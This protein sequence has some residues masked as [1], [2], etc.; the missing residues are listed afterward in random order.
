MRAQLPGLIL[1]YDATGSGR[2]LLLLHGYPLSRRIWQPQFET[3]LDAAW[4]VAPDLRGHGES[5]APEG[6]YTMDQLA[7]DAAALL[8]ELGI[9][10]PLVVGGLS[11]GGYVTLAFWRRHPQRVAGL[12]LA[13]TRAGAD[14]PEGRAARDKAA[15]TARDQGAAAIADAMLP[16]M[17][18]PGTYH[19]NPALVQRV[20]DLMAATPVTGIVGALAGIRDRPDSLAT[21]AGIDRPVLVIH[22]ADDQLIPPS[23]AEAMH[24]RLPNSRLEL[25]PGAG[26]L[27]NMEQ[28]A[29]FD[30]AVR[31]FLQSL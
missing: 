31:T 16:K 14:S 6:P 5:D 8:D 2:P 30:A 25:V 3:L 15:A 11:M 29:S 12:I 4:M 9:T 1:A 28:P 27:L 13:A 7:D 26:H 21:L 19:A 17:F 18:A 22:G 10:Q 24:A 20:R 23:E